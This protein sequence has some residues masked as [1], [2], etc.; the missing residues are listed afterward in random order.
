M[1]SKQ[2]LNQYSDRSCGCLL[3]VSPAPSIDGLEEEVGK[4][5]IFHNCCEKALILQFAQNSCDIEAAFREQQLPKATHN[6]PD[7]WHAK[8]NN[9]SQFHQ[10]WCLVTAFFS[11]FLMVFLTNSVEKP[12]N[13]LII[14]PLRS[15][16]MQ[17]CDR[18]SRETKPKLSKD[19]C[20]QGTCREN[21][22]GLGRITTE[23][24][25]SALSPTTASH[26]QPVKAH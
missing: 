24:C 26:S 10:P 1:Q 20:A 23:S 11:G 2:K 6:S 17:Y 14:Q 22:S 13:S 21:S 12:L 5:G 16:K 15:R 8:K 7:L 19:K 25:F 9:F 4:A 18:H 3:Q